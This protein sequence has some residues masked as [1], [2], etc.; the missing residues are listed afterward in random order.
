M[1]YLRIPLRTEKINIKILIFPD[2]SFH[3]SATILEQKKI[4]SYFKSSRYVPDNISIIPILKLA[5]FR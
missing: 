5:A 3:T 2:C 1:I 4:K